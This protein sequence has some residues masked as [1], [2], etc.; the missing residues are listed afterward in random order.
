MCRGAALV[1]AVVCIER[2]QI[3]VVDQV[4]HR[5]GKRAGDQLRLQ[6]HR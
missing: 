6:V 4:M 5:V 1:V 3:Q 2:R